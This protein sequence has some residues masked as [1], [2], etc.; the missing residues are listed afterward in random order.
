LS[1]AR[2]H[3]LPDFRASLWEYVDEYGGESPHAA[4]MM[5]QIFYITFAA[6]VL[7][8]YVLPSSALAGDQARSIIN[9]LDPKSMND[10]FEALKTQ[11]DAALTSINPAGPNKFRFLFV[12]STSSPIMTYERVGRSFA[13]R[14]A[15]FA[16]AMR[17]LASG[18]GLTSRTMFFGTAPYGGE[19]VNVAYRDIE[20]RYQFGLQS[21]CAGRYISAAE[22]EKAVAPPERRGYGAAI[23]DQPLE[24]TP[25]EEGLK[26]FLAPPPPDKPIE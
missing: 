20:V 5:R 19:D 13:E 24:A 18:F 7:A 17:P 3:F 4:G 10:L 22:L 21:P 11:P 8:N 15:G 25:P 6:S 14:F 1:I 12:W 26:P 9:G 16:E 23:P 2:L